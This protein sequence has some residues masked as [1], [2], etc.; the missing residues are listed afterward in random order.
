MCALPV[1]RGPGYEC[2]RALFLHIF[3]KVSNCAQKSSHLW[4]N[5]LSVG[6]FAPPPAPVSEAPECCMRPRKR[7]P[8]ISGLSP[9]NLSKA[10]RGI[11]SRLPEGGIPVGAPSNYGGSIFPLCGSS[12]PRSSS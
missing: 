8:H 5:F 10:G 4:F 12:R 1:E 6:C 9:L 11:T 2:G 3:F 7:E